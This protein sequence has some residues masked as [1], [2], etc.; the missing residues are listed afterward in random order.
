[1][2]L[3][4]AGLRRPLIKRFIGLI[5]LLIR[6]EILLENGNL[7]L[8]IGY[9][10]S[11]TER[12]GPAQ[13][14]ARFSKYIRK[15]AYQMKALKK[16]LAI[17]VMITAVLAIAVIPASAISGTKMDY[18]SY[19]AYGGYG[20]L[21]V[22]NTSYLATFKITLEKPSESVP[23]PTC[24]V[25]VDY[26]YE[27]SAGESSSTRVIQKGNMSCYLPGN[28]VGTSTITSASC[29]YWINGA[30]VGSLYI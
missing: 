12:K 21:T 28:V 15:G 25:R 24:E 22:T 30:Y 8:F 7:V 1:M 26:T 11:L 18:F 6:T 17:A 16:T 20:E 10:R 14:E 3:P 5:F 19:G 29:E 27:N 4:V 2:K 13:N 23:N 9:K